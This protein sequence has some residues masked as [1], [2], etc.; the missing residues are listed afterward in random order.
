MDKEFV[1]ICCPMGC[2]LKVEMNEKGEVLQ[3]SGNTCNRGYD[4][5]ISEVT[6]PTRMVTTTI[7]TAD[8]FSVPVKTKEP[9]PK[10]KIFDCMDEIKKT[11]VHLPVKVGQV[12][13]K[14]VAETHIDIIATRTIVI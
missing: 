1:C 2:H 12:L 10:G 7:R 14:N 11:E 5:A 9:I 3:V 6:S 13:I 4:Y 8:G